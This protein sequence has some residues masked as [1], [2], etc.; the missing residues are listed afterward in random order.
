LDPAEHGGT[1][2]ALLLGG[3]EW[4]MPAIAPPIAAGIK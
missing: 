1:F 2:G 3:L 4:P